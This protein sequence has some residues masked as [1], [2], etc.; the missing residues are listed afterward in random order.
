MDNKYNKM[1]DKPFEIPLNKITKYM[2]YICIFY[3]FFWKYAFDE[4]RIILYGTAGL[5]TLCM[6]IDLLISRRDILA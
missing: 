1:E 6:I 4:R 2:T 5:A 3:L